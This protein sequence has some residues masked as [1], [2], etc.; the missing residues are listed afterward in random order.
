MP[1]WLKYIP[2]PSGLSSLLDSQHEW[3]HSQPEWQPDVAAGCRSR[4]SNRVAAGVAI[5][6]RSRMSDVAAGGRIRVAAGGRIRVAVGVAIGVA[7]VAGRVAG[8]AAPKAS[9]SSG[10]ENVASGKKCVP[11][12]E[13]SHKIAAFDERRDHRSIRHSPSGNALRYQSGIPTGSD[14]ICLMPWT[15]NSPVNGTIQNLWS[16]AE[17]PESCFFKE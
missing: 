2:L 17:S 9:Q 12:V 1:F 5:G 15:C 3:P 14:I 11:G 6:C 16:W 8:V 10:D 4:S 7:V 13:K